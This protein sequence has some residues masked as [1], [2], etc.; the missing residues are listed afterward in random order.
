MIIWQNEVC[1]HLVGAATDIG[2]FAQ[3][4]EAGHRHEDGLQVDAPQVHEEND[5][6]SFTFSRSD[7][8]LEYY[9]NVIFKMSKIEFKHLLI[10]LKLFGNIFFK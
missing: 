6:K 4:R 2:L 7:T 10:F 8:F 3:Q 9:V 1:G 5:L